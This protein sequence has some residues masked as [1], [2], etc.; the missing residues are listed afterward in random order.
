[1]VDLQTQ[2]V[3]TT[4]D[5]FKGGACS[6]VAVVPGSAQ[7]VAA[8]AATV[9][10][11][12]GPENDALPSTWDTT[13]GTV[14]REGPGEKCP[15][16]ALAAAASTFVS[17]A[18]DVTAWFWSLPNFQADGVQETVHPPN[19]SSLAITFDGTT[20]IT[21]G[22]ANQWPNVQIFL[23]G[24]T[25]T[26]TIVFT[27]SDVNSPWP[28]CVAIS[29]D[30]Q[31]ALAGAGNQTLVC[32]VQQSEVSHTLNLAA[33]AIAFT[34]DGH[35]FVA[36]PNGTVVLLDPETWTAES[37]S[38]SLGFTPAMI[39]VSPLWPAGPIVVTGTN[40]EVAIM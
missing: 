26:E 16:A 21:V 9:N 33:A 34:P 10:L 37:G 22:A 40:G 38:L 32:D 14:L 31:T 3:T 25:G 7:V 6:A 8:S 29:P 17:L 1:M 28:S 15:V 12:V 19:L 39:S 2:V 35:V 13:Y 4:L 5:P 36:Q 20:A 11:A 30:A 24:P 23:V 18:S 27:A